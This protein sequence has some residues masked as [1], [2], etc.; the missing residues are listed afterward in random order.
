MADHSKRYIVKHH[1]GLLDQKRGQL[2][3]RL[4]KE[5]FVAAQIVQMVEAPEENDDVQ[6]VASNFV[7]GEAAL[8]Q[9]P[10]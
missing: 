1:K 2:S 3:H 7:G 10:R 6:N 9:L 8:A 5:I 4:A